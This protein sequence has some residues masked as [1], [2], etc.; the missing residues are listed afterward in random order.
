MIVGWLWICLILLTAGMYFLAKRTIYAIASC[1]ALIPLFFDIFSID[2]IWQALAFVV[3]FVGAILVCTFVF[4]GAKATG[5][6]PDALVGAKCTVVERIDEEAGC[7][8]VRVGNQLWSA[9]SVESV[10]YENGEVL[11]VV[12]IEGVKLICRK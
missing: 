6:S 10:V 12:A 3:V 8:L 1:S 2:L 4:P 5:S 11:R 7:G 9:R